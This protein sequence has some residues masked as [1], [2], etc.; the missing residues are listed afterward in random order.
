MLK[1]Y[2][3]LWTTHTDVFRIKCQSYQFTKEFRL[4]WLSANMT[5]MI[6]LQY[7]IYIVPVIS[8]PMTGLWFMTISPGNVVE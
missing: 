4:F 5:T 6:L 1:Y 3:C 7:V 2:S 8:Q